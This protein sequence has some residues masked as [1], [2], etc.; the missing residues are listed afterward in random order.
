MVAAVPSEWRVQLTSYWWD[1]HKEEFEERTIA[2]ARADMDWA[3]IHASGESRA[4]PPF[5]YASALA[6]Y[7]LEEAEAAARAERYL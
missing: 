7:G 5:M 1:L 3:Y 4:G 2:P 6:A